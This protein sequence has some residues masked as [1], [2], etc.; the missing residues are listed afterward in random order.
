MIAHPNEQNQNEYAEIRRKIKK[1]CS[2][3]KKRY[4]ESRLQTLQN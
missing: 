4:Y 1:V 2:Q 3:K